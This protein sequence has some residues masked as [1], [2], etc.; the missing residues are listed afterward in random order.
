M[1]L[2]RRELAVAMREER[3]LRA[4]EEVHRAD[5]PVEEPEPT[6]DIV[7]LLGLRKPPATRLAE[8]GASQHKKKK[9]SPSPD[10]STDDAAPRD[11]C[12]REAPSSSSSS[13]TS[14]RSQHSRSSTAPASGGEQPR[15]DSSSKTPA[16]Q[17]PPQ[18]CTSCK[19]KEQLDALRHGLRQSEIEALKQSARADAALKRVEELEQ[20]LKAAEARAAAAEASAAAVPA[21]SPAPSSLPM[22]PAA[23]PV[24]PEA[25][26]PAP[27]PAPPQPPTAPAAPAATVAEQPPLPPAPTQVSSSAGQLPPRDATGAVGAQ[28][29]TQDASSSSSCGQSTGPVPIMSQGLLPGYSHAGFGFDGA[30]GTWHGQRPSAHWTGVA[31]FSSAVPPAASQADDAGMFSWAA[32]LSGCAKRA[33]PAPACHGCGGRIPRY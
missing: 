23:V 26:P 2:R 20:A 11:A 14:P 27:A 31:P 10:N 21:S 15:K 19:C 18:Q 6:Q 5:E 9:K 22:A 24:V 25:E 33:T 30:A 4:V 13:S 29:S 32:N 7:E 1:E 17:E 3:L 8:T 12:S 16:A 28:S